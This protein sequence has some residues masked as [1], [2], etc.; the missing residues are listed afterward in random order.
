MKHATL[1]RSLFYTALCMAGLGLSANVQ[2]ASVSYFLNQSNALADGPN[3]LRVT[4]DNAGAPG[5]INFTVETLS[6]LN[7]LAS[8]NFGI[9]DFGFSTSI[10]LTSISESNITGLPTGW[11]ANIVPPPNQLDGFGRFEI[12]AAGSGT[13]RADP[14]TFSISGVAGDTINDYSVLSTGTA[15]QGNVFYAAHVAGFCYGTGCTTSSAYFGGSTVVPL[16]GA[17]WLFGSGLMGMAAVMRRNRK[18]I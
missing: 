9:Q 4:I 5:A 6:A 2:A 18:K 12:S 8:S 13:T 14:L 3:Y 16:P 10:P 7:S 1:L 11:I 15:G 17:V